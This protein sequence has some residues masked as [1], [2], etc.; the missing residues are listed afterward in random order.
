MPDDW[1]P[2][3]EPAP[4]DDEEPAWD[5]LNDSPHADAAAVF[6]QLLRMGLIQ[7]DIG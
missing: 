3:P 7:F 2:G 5:L 4:R 6:P 1:Q